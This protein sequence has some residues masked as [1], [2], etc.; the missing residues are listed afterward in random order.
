MSDVEVGVVHMLKRAKPTLMA[1]EII[2][3]L[4]HTFGRV[5]SEVDISHAIKDWNPFGTMSRQKLESHAVEHCPI[6][7]ALWRLR[8]PPL[9]H[10]GV[11]RYR[12]IDID[13]M[14]V[15]ITTCN[16]HYGH[17]YVGERAV[18]VQKY[19][20]GSKFTVVLGISPLGETF[21]DIIEDGNLD[22]AGFVLFLER[23]VLPF[24][25]PNRVLLW[26][27][28]KAHLGA[29]V[30]ALVANAALQPATAGLMSLA[31]PPYTPHWGPIEFAFGVIESHLRRLQFTV[32][33]GN[34]RQCLMVA[35]SSV[36]SAQMCDNIFIDLKY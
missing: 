18:E 19:L 3:A 15:F 24:C 8:P 14:G 20:P 32:T 7:R 31:R 16:R 4:A 23:K 6:M 10:I 5:F 33:S 28:L 36:L 1:T 25:G 34:F 27:N 35:I 11:N 9:G 26:D 13:E 12:M 17:G 30:Q 22:Q 21:L 2:N 29:A